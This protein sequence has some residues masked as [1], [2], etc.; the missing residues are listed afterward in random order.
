M[1]K[2]KRLRRDL[3]KERF[4]QTIE[5]NGLMRLEH[6]PS[7]LPFFKAGRLPGLYMQERKC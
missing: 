4:D 6:V 5:K 7:G 2:I 1:D 3:F